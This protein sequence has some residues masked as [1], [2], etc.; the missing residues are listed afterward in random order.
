MLEFFENLPQG[1]FF[2]STGTLDFSP[3]FSAAGSLFSLFHNIHPRYAIVQLS[4]LSSYI[5][6]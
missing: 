6:I 3:F 4:L 1:V 5:V 2:D